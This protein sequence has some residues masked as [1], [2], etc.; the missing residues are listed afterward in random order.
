MFCSCGGSGA[1]AFRFKVDEVGAGRLTSCLFPVLRFSHFPHEEEGPGGVLPDHIDKGLVHLE[2]DGPTG[3][4]SIEHLNDGDCCRLGAL[5]LN[6]DE[7]LV[8]HPRDKESVRGC[9]VAEIGPIVKSDAQSQIDQ[10][11]IQEGF[12]SVFKLG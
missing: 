11:I 5:F 1:S 8:D 3:D 4:G 9:D 6:V 7:A 2:K 12:E 10:G